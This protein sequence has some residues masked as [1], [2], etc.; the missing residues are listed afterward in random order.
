VYAL[1]VLL[2]ELLTGQPPFDARTLMHAGHEEMRRVISEVQPRKPSDFGRRTS[3]QELA[4]AG[5]AG[6]GTRST[7]Q[8]MKLTIDRDLDLIT[9]RALEKDRVRRYESATAFAEDIQRFLNHEPVSA[10]APSVLYLGRRW[11]RRHR[12]LAVAAGVCLLAV[13]AGSS[14]AVWQAVRATRSEARAIANAQDADAAMRMIME[15]LRDFDPTK[16]GRAVTREDLSRELVRRVKQFSGDPVRKADMLLSLAAITRGEE[17]LKVLDEALALAKP[18]LAADDPKLWQV[19]FAR[20]WRE[21]NHNHPERI[22]EGIDEL[23]ELLPWARAHFGERDFRTVRCGYELGRGLSITGR[24]EE[25]LGLLAQACED[26]RRDPGVASSGERSFFRMDYAGALFQT[27]RKAEALAMS[28]ENVRIM[29]AEHGAGFYDTGRAMFRHAGLCRDA[30]E[31]TEATEAARR[32]LEGFLASVGPLDDMYGMTLDLLLDLLRQQDDTEGQLALRRDVLRAHDDKLGP[33][34]GRTLQRAAEYQGT[35][36]AAKRPDEADKLATSWLERR[37]TPEGAIPAD[38]EQLLRP[39]IGVLRGSAQWPRA[40]A[41]LRDLIA[42]VE[43][44]RPEDLQRWGDMD[45]LGEVLNQQHKFA[46]AIPVLEQSI[47]G[48]EKAK[49]DAVKRLHLPQAKRRLETARS[50]RQEK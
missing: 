30:G 11:A 29:V 34:H 18:V 39:H 4:G 36:I 40:E 45:N 3:R 37:R 25:A 46:E 16:K 1:G 20:A 6:D 49:D 23:R 28:R 2:Y 48:L 9:L 43:R 22:Q 41:A 44:A 38:C 32:A 35:L 33:K 17:T 13:V 8:G 27:G 12:T 10:R 7:T 26:I 5:E 15:S 19:R 24:G 47:A 14:V 31:L 42:L 50:S 21:A